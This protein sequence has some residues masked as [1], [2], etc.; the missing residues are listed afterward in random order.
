MNKLY[1]THDILAYNTSLNFEEKSIILEKLIFISY[2]T[3]FIRYNIK[4]GQDQKKKYK[5]EK[6][7]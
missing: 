3:N 2:E 5:K 6:K 1:N 4:E 7:Y